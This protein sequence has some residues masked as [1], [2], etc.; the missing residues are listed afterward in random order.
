MER[1]VHLRLAINLRRSPIPSFEALCGQP[2][3]CPRKYT[4]STQPSSEALCGQL[5]VY[6][7][8][9]PH[10]L[11][12]LRPVRP[13]AYHPP[14]APDFVTTSGSGE[15]KAHESPHQEVRLL[16]TK[17]RHPCS[18]KPSSEALCVKP[19]QGRTWSLAFKIAYAHVCQLP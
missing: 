12:W 11:W 10:I 17:L 6:S 18:T 19:S 14:F 8:R 3:P 4:S 13:A 9:I 7:P 15:A 5:P 1:R 16:H 2:S